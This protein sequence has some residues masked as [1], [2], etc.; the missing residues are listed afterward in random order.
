MTVGSI[1]VCMCT[2]LHSIWNM[3]YNIHLMVLGNYVEPQLVL[4]LSFPILLQIIYSCIT[5]CKCLRW[6]LKH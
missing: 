3:P 1:I 6:K 2:L 4:I 5:L